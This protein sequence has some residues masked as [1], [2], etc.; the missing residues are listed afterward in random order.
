MLKNCLYTEN[1]VLN[2][3]SYHNHLVALV[4]PNRE[5]LL[6]LADQLGKSTDDFAKLCEDA[7][8]KKEVTDELI[9]YGKRNGL[10]SKEVPYVIKLCPE[11]WNPQNG[12][13]TA[14][15]KTRRAPIYQFYESAVKECYK[16]LES[17]FSVN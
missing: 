14:T 5:N 3:D 9:K 10:L 6:K 7:R 12:L 16:E 13:L 2:G 17:K 11:A 8:I 4:Q 1:I 15:L